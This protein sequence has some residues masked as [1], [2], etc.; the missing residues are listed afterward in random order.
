MTDT[1]I[2]LDRLASLIRLV[3]TRG[4]TELVVE[5]DGCRY[6]IRGS[7][8]ESA[9]EEPASDRCEPHGESC[10]IARTAIESPMVG[11]FY[12]S[13]APNQRP[14]V[15]VG[16]TVEA[17]QIV[18]LIEAMKVFSEVPSEQAGVVDEI[19]VGDG[20]LVRAGQALMYLRAATATGE[21]E[22]EH[23]H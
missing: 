21:D 9:P 18:G 20:D 1:P 4:L 11:V 16:D 6:A 7:G 3:E 12:R 2:D 5:E 19:A 13:P 15:E 10:P 17:G 23:D 14:Y 8:V 22:D